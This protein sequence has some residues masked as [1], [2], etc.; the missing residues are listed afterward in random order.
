MIRLSTMKRPLLSDIRSIYFVILFFTDTFTDAVYSRE[1]YQIN[2]ENAKYQNQ[3]KQFTEQCAAS[4]IYSIIHQNIITWSTK[5]RRPISYKEKDAGQSGGLCSFP[6]QICAFVC[7]FALPF[8]SSRQTLWRPQVKAKSST[9]F[10]RLIASSACGH[11]R[12][13]RRLPERLAP[14]LQLQSPLLFCFSTRTKESI[15]G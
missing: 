1:S 9:T 2:Y 5:I 15:M 10:Q 3:A 11:F 12:T 6:L 4:L 8:R 14:H 13:L 7:L